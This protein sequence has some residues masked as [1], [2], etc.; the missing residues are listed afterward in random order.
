MAELRVTEWLKIMVEE[1]D[2][3]RVESQQAGEEERLRRESRAPAGTA[4]SGA[5][6]PDR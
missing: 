6:R 4:G 1:V 2:R 5:Q 3:K